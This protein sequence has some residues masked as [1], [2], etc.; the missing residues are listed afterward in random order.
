MSFLLSTSV[1]QTVKAK[2]DYAIEKDSHR[3]VQ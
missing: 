2:K 1:V 3:I